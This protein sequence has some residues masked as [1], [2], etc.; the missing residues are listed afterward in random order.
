VDPY[1]VINKYLDQLLSIVLEASLAKS[2]VR[3]FRIIVSHLSDITQFG[4]A[5]ASYSAITSLTFISPATVLPRIVDQLKDDL[6]PA[7]LNSLTDDDLAIWATPE[8]TTFVDGV[9]SNIVIFKPYLLLLS[10]PFIDTSRGQD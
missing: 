10:S 8:G 3:T 2:R 4:F 6:D 9:F 5:E 7:I 1:E